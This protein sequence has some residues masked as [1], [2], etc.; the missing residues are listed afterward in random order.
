[1]IGN[2]NR[3]DCSDS[4]NDTTNKA[5]FFSRNPVVSASPED[6]SQLISQFLDELSDF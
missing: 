6:R 3:K 4:S 2:S 5:L 1:M